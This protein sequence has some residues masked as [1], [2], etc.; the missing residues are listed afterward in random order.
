[1]STETA[2]PLED[3][4]SIVTSLRSANPPAAP[5]ESWLDAAI[6]GSFSCSSGGGNLEGWITFYDGT[7]VHYQI[8]GR[9]TRIVGTAAG[10]IAVPLIRV[11]P[12]DNFAGKLGNFSVSGFWTAGNLSL[13]CDGR[14]I[15]QVPIPVGSVAPWDY[16]ME[17]NVQ[18]TRG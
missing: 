17:G 1:M 18:Y 8:S 7:K 3:L 15:T 12:V 11:L 5:A 13:V 16:V 9:P 2:L 6:T 14:S 4:N 10:V